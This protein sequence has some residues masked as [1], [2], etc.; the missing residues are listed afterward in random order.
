MAATST[1]SSPSCGKR[2][3]PRSS[4]TLASLAIRIAGLAAT[5]RT[6]SLS[7]AASGTRVIARLFSSGSHQMRLPMM[8][9]SLLLGVFAAAAA[10]LTQPAPSP[11]AGDAA[12]FVSQLEAQGVQALNL[13]PAQRAA[14]FR[15]LFQA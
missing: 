4:G 15:Q 8:R 7:G 3:R 14:R 5:T 9:R 6:G 1:G 11:A 10:L 13:P 2:R 12:G